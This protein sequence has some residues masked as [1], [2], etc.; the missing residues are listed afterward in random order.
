MKRLLLIILLGSQMLPLTS[1]DETRF[2]VG[3]LVLGANIPKV[4]Q[5]GLYLLEQLVSRTHT[6]PLMPQGWMMLDNSLRNAPPFLWLM[7]GPR[8]E[9]DPE[10]ILRLQRFIATGGTIFAESDG[11]LQGDGLLKSLHQGIFAKSTQKNLQS[12]EL[13]T[14][15]FYIIPPSV[16]NPIRIMK[17]QGRI[18]CIESS[19]PLLETMIDNEN[20]TRMGVNIVIYTLT[21]SYKDDLTHVKYLMR[22]RKN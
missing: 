21:G 6:D 22:R 7:V 16:I 4:R 8:A 12:G 18:A 17:S 9:T 13:L 20:A 1:A 11:S 2:S 14:R 5:A 10:L 15:T 3:C 19:Q